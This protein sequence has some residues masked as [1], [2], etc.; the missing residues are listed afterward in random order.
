MLPGNQPGSGTKMSEIFKWLNKTEA[1]SDLTS[2]IASESKLHVES[3]QEVSSIP[4]HPLEPPEITFSHGKFDL[5][6]ADHR[7]KTA[8]NAQT[9]PGEQFRFLRTRLGQLQRQK[10]IKKLLITS[11]TP[12]EGKTF[13][14]CCLAAILAQEPGKRVLLIDADL[15][16]PRAAHNFGLTEA[17]DFS[18]L[19]DVLQ[20]TLKLQEALLRSSGLELFY[21]PAGQVPANP[22]ELLA[23]DSLEQIIANTAE[24]FDWVIIDSPPVLNFSDSTRLASLC[25]SVVVVVA[26]NG[27]PAKMV[28]KSLEMLGKNMVCGIVMN[29]L[30]NLR[31]TQYYY[32]YYSRDGKRI[33][34]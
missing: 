2:V 20:G 1:R 8:L 22:S 34:K 7:V 31:T 23:S 13:V 10:G 18:G 11:S 15:R 29:K 3:L 9:L 32:H 28:H 27:T 33:K 6:L 21:L 17:G 12:G 25:D 4:V 24:L 30:Q 16:R 5:D 19:S 26:A 14:S